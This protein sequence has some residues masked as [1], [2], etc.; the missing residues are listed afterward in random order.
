M[1]NNKIEYWQLKRGIR[2]KKELAE[3]VGVTPS[4][5][6]AWE[7]GEYQPGKFNL[8]KLCKALNVRESDLYPNESTQMS[9][10]D[11][12]QKETKPYTYIGGKFIND[13]R[14]I[15][16]NAGYSGQEVADAIG[17]NP[18][19]YFEW[20]KCNANPPADAYLKL[21]EFYGLSLEEIVKAAIKRPVEEL[22][23]EPNNEELPKKAD[24]VTVEVNGNA[25]TIPTEIFVSIL[26]LSNIE[27]TSIVVG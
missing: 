14:A 6:S 1:S 12:K 24:T 18:S 16:T 3:L 2:Q 5:I 7:H 21:S 27:N 10:D 19:T 22:P 25:V 15:R 8:K 11:E 9:F 20:E 13:L 17:F 26:G 23:K 4:T